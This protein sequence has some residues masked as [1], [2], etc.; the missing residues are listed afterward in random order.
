MSY[1]IEAF[2]ENG[3]QV[4]STN[5][6]VYV[7]KREGLLFSSEFADEANSTGVFYKH[8]IT[9]GA[10]TSGEEILMFD[11]EEGVPIGFPPRSD[12]ETLGEV[13]Y[14]KQNLRYVVMAPRVTLP[15]PTDAEAAV[16][17]ENGNCI[18]DSDSAVV[19][20][21][22]GLTRR[23]L[24]RGFERV[25]VPGEFAPNLVTASHSSLI[26]DGADPLN[27]GA[28]IVCLTFNDSTDGVNSYID[29]QDQQFAAFSAFGFKVEFEFTLSVLYGYG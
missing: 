19:R 16:F 21:S 4:L 23:N 5:R 29:I 1:G 9:G 17:D 7:K 6:I 12:P 24:T 22:G 14:P 15:A 26:I 2:N 28:Y 25:F 3:E 27:P 8:Y 20:I 18:W 11:A 13:M 10:V